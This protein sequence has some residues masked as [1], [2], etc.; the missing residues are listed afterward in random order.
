LRGG[1]CR[2]FLIGKTDRPDRIGEKERDSGEG[3]NDKHNCPY[4]R[5]SFLPIRQYIP[6]PV[7]D[8]GFP[9]GPG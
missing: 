7:Y 5:M 9:G 3:N 6:S 1:R 4:H 2:S 8:G